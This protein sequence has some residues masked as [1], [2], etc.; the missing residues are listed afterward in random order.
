MNQSIGEVSYGLCA[1]LSTGGSNCDLDKV[2]VERD[3]STGAL[4]GSICSSK[5]QTVTVN[6]SMVGCNVSVGNGSTGG[7]CLLT[8]EE[9]SRSK[10][11]SVTSGQ[12]ETASA[13][14]SLSYSVGISNGD[15]AS[16]K[17]LAGSILGYRDACVSNAGSSSLDCGR[18][19]Y[20][21]SV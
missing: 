20:V 15:D 16:I 1:S 21:W 8:S 18:F 13:T 6:S 7:G 19:L 2:N 4:A 12:S 11:L 17:A 3:A 14:V 9:Y 5:L 10:R